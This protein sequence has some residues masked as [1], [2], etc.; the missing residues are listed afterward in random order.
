MAGVPAQTQVNPFNATGYHAQNNA[1]DTQLA[2]TANQLD[3]ITDNSLRVNALLGASSAAIQ[4]KGQNNLNLDNAYSQYGSQVSAAKN[5]DNQTIY[6]VARGYAGDNKQAHLGIMEAKLK[7]INNKSTIL[8]TAFRED[9][10]GLRGDKAL[11]ANMIFSP[12][13][14]ARY[15]QLL[16]MKRKG[17]LTITKN[18]TPEQIAQINKDL[19][20]LA[21][22]EERSR[23]SYVQQ[24]SMPTYT[25]MV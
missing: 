3:T 11:R 24:L 25:N 13:D 6:N 14:N 4:A 15:N 1:I 19:A 18:T 7:E 20:E 8:D 21:D 16:L 5:Q 9:I 22:L 23:N 10:Q 12:Q 2:G 17:D